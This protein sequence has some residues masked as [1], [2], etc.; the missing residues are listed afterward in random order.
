M[1]NIHIFL[2][3]APLF[4]TPKQYFTLTHQKTQKNSYHI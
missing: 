2:L 1:T 3:Y 4:T